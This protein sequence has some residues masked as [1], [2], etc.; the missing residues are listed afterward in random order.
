MK[1]WS[2][3]I[4]RGSKLQRSAQLAACLLACLSAA[5]ADEIDESDAADIRIVSSRQQLV[6]GERL[7]F[8]GRWIGL[9]VGK[10]WIEVKERLELDGRQVYHVQAEGVSTDL[11]AKFYPIH[12]VVHSY[13]DAETLQP[14]R[15]EK[16]QREGH[17]RAEE[18][19][20]FDYER[21][22][23]GYQSLLRPDRPDIEDS[24]KAVPIPADVHDLISAFYWLRRQ[25]L[26]LG[27]P[28]WVNI[29][30]DE[31]VYPTEM[32]PVKGVRLELRKRGTFEAVLVEPKPK[33]KGLM[34]KRGRIWVYMSA[35]AKRLPLYVKVATPWGPMSAVIDRA[36]LK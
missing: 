4:T 12:D 8:T 22:V 2:C 27:R 25:P 1:A 16:H 5:Q 32:L 17:Y 3:P 15:F 21:L 24:R 30:S 14:V 23:A 34:V 9:P 31:K 35:D 6:V 36:S 11:L 28:L 10:G 13:L 18:V 7:S 29:Y 20:T 33:F 26:E 19:V